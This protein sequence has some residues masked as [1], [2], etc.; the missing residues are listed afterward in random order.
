MKYRAM[1][2]SFDGEHKIEG[3]FD[4][5]DQAWEYINNVGSRWYFYPFCFVVKGLTVVAV[6]DQIVE[7]LRGKRIKTVAKIFKEHSERPDT[8]GMEPEEFLITL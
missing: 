8:L 4:T 3:S 5:I 6:P 7:F 2:M 1:F